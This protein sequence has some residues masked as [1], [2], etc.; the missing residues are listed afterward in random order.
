M[1]AVD[2][3][4]ALGRVLHSGALRDAF[5][6][7]AVACV[8]RIGLR[9]SDWPAFL[10]L[11]PADLEFQARTLLRKRFELV[12]RALPA[13]CTALGRE[14]WPVF[15]RYGRLNAPAGRDPT[16]GDILGFA[17]HLDHESNESLDPGELNRCRFVCGSRRLAG[18][19]VISPRRLGLPTLQILLRQGSGRWQ[20][21]RLYLSF[22]KS[23]LAAC[24]AS[25]AN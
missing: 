17:L 14:A 25:A 1:A 24:V 4:T 23:P 18:H 7:D 16:N 2:F 19:I 21:W 6:A 8:R 11:A 15:E 13:T 20:E 22:R 12:R 10:Q 9:E 5:A 3:I